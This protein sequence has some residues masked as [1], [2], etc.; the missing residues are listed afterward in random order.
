[1]VVI[2]GASIVW[3]IWFMLVHAFLPRR[4]AKALLEWQRSASD[5][6]STLAR[7]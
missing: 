4:A 5:R 6:V 7:S 1:V 2:L 3:P